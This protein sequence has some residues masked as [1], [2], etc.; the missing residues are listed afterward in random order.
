MLMGIN[1]AA[2]VDSLSKMGLGML[3]IF[4]VT[5]IIV[6]CIYWLNWLFKKK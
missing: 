1:V 6:A 3:G 2:F 5:A 4:I